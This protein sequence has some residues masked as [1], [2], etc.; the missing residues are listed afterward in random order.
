MVSVLAIKVGHL[1]LCNCSHRL[2]DK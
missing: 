1:C 2:L